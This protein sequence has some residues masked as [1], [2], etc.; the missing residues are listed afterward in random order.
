MA[1][2][3]LC[4]HSPILGPPEFTQIGIFGFENKQPGNP[5]MIQSSES[6]K[7][8]LLFF[9]RGRCYDHNFPNFRRKNC[10]FT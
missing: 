9:A 3:Y 8:G 4:Q 5:A 1:I 2:K 6:D 7:R 10:R